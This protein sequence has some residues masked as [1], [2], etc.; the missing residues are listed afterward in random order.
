MNRTEF[1][2]YILEILAIDGT[3]AR[4]IQNI[5]YFLESNYDNAIDQREKAEDLLSGIGLTLQE[6]HKIDFTKEADT[7]IIETNQEVSV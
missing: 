5:L 3:T 1:Y 2:N 7:G 4:I 6:I